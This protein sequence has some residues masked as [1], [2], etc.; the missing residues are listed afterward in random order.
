[1]TIVSLTW[2]EIY[3]CSSVAAMRIIANIRDRRQPRFGAANGEG[4]YE[5]Q[6]IGCLGEMAVA[7]H[8]NLF[9]GGSVGD[10]KAVDVGG[11]VQV[12]ACSRADRRLILHHEDDDARPFVLAIVNDLPNVTLRGWL[13]AGDGK[14]QNYWEDPVGGRPA[15][16]VPQTC[17]R[18]MDELKDDHRLRE[19]LRRLRDQDYDRGYSPE[20]YA[21]AL[22]SGNEP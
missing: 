11:K 3:L 14:Q 15:F 21:D 19:G 8:C 7:K 18:P 22:L 9:W 4:S 13:L 17:L 16:F 2:P 10:F 1:M 12:R 6:W 20:A 5:I